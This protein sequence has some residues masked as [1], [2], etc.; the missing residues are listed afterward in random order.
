LNIAA[1]AGSRRQ[2]S[3]PSSSSRGG[4]ARMPYAQ[5]EIRDDRYL[6]QRKTAGREGNPA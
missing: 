4:L 1:C 5:T 6:I 3:H 2:E